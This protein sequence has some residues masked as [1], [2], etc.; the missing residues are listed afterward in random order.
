MKT[1]ALSLL[2]TIAIFTSLTFEA[3]HTGH[4]AVC[5]EDNCPVCLVLQLVRNTIKLAGKARIPQVKLPLFY[6]EFI[7]SL[8]TI[9]FISIT[10]VNQKRKL[11]I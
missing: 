8:F 9:Y 6:E 7:I 4:E 1:R 5:Q 10:L 11:T 3:F 2:L